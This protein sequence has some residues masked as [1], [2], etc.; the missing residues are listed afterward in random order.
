MPFPLLVFQTYLKISVHCQRGTEKVHIS[1]AAHHLSSL[2]SARMLLKNGD[3]SAYVDDIVSCD[4]VLQPKPHVGVYQKVVV[5][6]QYYAPTHHNC[7]T[8]N[9]STKPQPEVWIKPLLFT[10]TYLSFPTLTHTYPFTGVGR[11]NAGRWVTCVAG[12]CARLGLHRRHACRCVRME[13]K[14]KVIR[15]SFRVQ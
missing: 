11:Y 9:H 10:P 5:A 15:I 13:R 14:S 7:S 8:C 12:V 3:L 4:T 1:T 6:S 2:Q